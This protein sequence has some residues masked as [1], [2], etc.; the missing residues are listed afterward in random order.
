MCLLLETIRLVNGSPMHL[1]VHQ[2]RMDRSR[3]ALFGEVPP[4]R[5]DSLTP[6][7]GIPGVAKWRILYGK[8]VAESGGMT[9]IPKRIRSVKLVRGDT[10]SYPFKLADRKIFEDLLALA[11]GCDDVLIIRRGRIT[12]LS[13]ANIAF[14]DGTGWVTPDTPLLEG[15]CRARLLKE[16]RLKEIPIRPGDLSNYREATV[17]NAMLEPGEMV[18]PVTAI[19]P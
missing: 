2:A 16:G 17:I 15:T 4:L 6:P 19:T 8:E 7:Q 10:I 13:Y 14:S 3:K 18:F 11:D 5:L 1:A 9:Y 12:D